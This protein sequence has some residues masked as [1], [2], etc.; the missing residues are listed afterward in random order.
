[1]R[2]QFLI[3]LVV[4]I[5][6]YLLPGH[7]EAQENASNPLAAVNSTDGRL[8]YMDLG[9]AYIT[10]AWL[11]GAYMLNPK[12][13]L[14]YELHHWTSNVTGTRLNNFESLHLKGIWFPTQ[15]ELGSWKYK[16]AIGLEWIKGWGNDDLVL[17]YQK[18]WIQCGSTRA[19]C[20]SFIG[21][22]RHRAGATVAAL[23]LIRWSGGE[24]DCCAVDCHSVACE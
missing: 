21:E 10:D 19:V 9:G 3:I 2:N 1:M 14:K 8:Q 5:A 20:R 7:A 4:V 17:G 22:R 16:P 24:N 18:Y 15:G 6:G 11:D 12:V 23:F 13:K